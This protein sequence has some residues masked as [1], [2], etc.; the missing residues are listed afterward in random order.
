MEYELRSLPNTS[1]PKMNRCHE[2]IDGRSAQTLS[3]ICSDCSD[4]SDC[5]HERPKRVSLRRVVSFHVCTR[6]YRWS[7]RPLS[8]CRSDATSAQCTL[9]KGT[10]RYKHSL[11]LYYGNSLTLPTFPLIAYFRI[12]PPLYLVVSIFIHIHTM[13]LQQI[14]GNIS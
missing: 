14:D 6:T 10:L 11:L 5:A 1:D 2:E 7:K 8:R 4:C 3:E 13:V 12:S 9:V